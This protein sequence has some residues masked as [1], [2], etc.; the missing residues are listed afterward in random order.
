MAKTD[1]GVFNVPRHGEMHLAPGIVPIKCESK[2]LRSFPVSANCVVLF[3]YANK[4]LDV[5][6]V[7]VLHAKVFDDKCETDGGLVV[8]PVPWHDLALS[9]SG[10]VE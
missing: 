4:M 2:V 8:S 3:Q 6:L 5:V 7:D 10:F 9:I 1:E